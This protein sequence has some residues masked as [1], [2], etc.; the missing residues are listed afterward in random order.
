MKHMSQIRS[1]P[2]VG[3]KLENNIWNHHLLNLYPACLMYGTKNK[4]W[5]LKN[6]ESSF[7]GD[8]VSKLVGGWTNPFEKY[9]SNGNSPNFRGETTGQKEYRPISYHTGQWPRENPRQHVSRGRFFHHQFFKEGFLSLSSSETK[10]FFN[11]GNDFQG[12]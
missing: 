12:I 3:V 11:G 8:F 9:E 1:F 2:Q 7:F 4:F 5:N 10:H 6:P